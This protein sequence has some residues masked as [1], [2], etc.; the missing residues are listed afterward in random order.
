MNLTGNIK[1]CLKRN[2][3]REK[4]VSKESKSRR[5][6]ERFMK[7]IFGKLRYKLNKYKRLQPTEKVVLKISRVQMLINPK[8][9]KVSSF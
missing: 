7:E 9:H 6:K 4:T 5:R 2:W 1:A 3:K 8:K